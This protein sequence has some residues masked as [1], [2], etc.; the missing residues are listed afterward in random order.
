MYTYMVCFVPPEMRQLWNWLE[1]QGVQ[2]HLFDRGNAGAGEQKMPDR[3]LQ[4]RMLEDVLDYNGTPGI[5]VPLTG[6]RAGYLEGA[7]FH[8][9]L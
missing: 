2:V 7:A 4:L 3:V 9:T 8:R 5:V 1:G 6:D